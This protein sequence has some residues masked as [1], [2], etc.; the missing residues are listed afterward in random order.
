VWG[1]TPINPN[2]ITQAFSNDPND[3]PFQDVGFDGLNDEEEVLRRRDDFLTPLQTILGPAAFQRLAADPSGDNF[4]NYRDSRYDASGAGILRRYKDFNLNQGNSP[5]STE[6]D[7][8][9]ASTLYPDNEDLNRDNTLN[10]G[11]EFFEYKVDF[12]PQ[13]LQVGQ[14]FIT[15][16]RIVSIKYENGTTGTETWYQFRIPIAR[17]TKKVG[18]IPDFKSIRFMRM[19]M[20]GWEDSVTLRFARL[21]LVR[22][23]WRQFAFD[24]TRNGTYNSNANNTFTSINTLAVNIE[25]K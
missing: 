25:E 5:V 3:R 7:L 2:Q 20:H 4:V 9:V 12:T 1:K 17:Y 24:L 21:D 18:D 8:V 14:N 19:Y 10:E 13:A 6:A 15:D 23:N 16:K 22:N 11:E